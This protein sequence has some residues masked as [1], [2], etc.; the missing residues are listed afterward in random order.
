MR[1]RL[2]GAR[3]GERED[4][5][6][7]GIGAAPTWNPDQS[8]QYTQRAFSYRISVCTSKRHN[9]CMSILVSFVS[10]SM[11]EAISVMRLEIAMAVKV[12][13]YLITT[14]SYIPAQLWNVYG[15]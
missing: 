2:S 15:L 4:Y 11:I 6:P 3:P 8:M 1:E 5:R 12:Q 14:T 9:G 7:T 10:A 13:P